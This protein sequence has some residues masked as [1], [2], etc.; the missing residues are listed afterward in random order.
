[1]EENENENEKSI[2]VNGRVCMNDNDKSF[3]V[4]F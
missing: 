4:V 2:C 1:M 3:A